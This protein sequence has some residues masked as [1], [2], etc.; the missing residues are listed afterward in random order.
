MLKEEATYDSKPA[1]ASPPHLWKL[2]VDLFTGAA[3]QANN[4]LH[5]FDNDFTSSCPYGFIL[6]DWQAHVKC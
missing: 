1:E 4:K 3:C 6:Y 5:R 2:F